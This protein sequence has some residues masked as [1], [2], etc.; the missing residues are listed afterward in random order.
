MTVTGVVLMGFDKRIAG[1]GVLRVPEL[2]LWVVAALGGALGIFLGM[3]IFRHKT[4]KAQFQF[5]LLGVFVAQLF[6]GKMV[7]QHLGIYS[8]RELLGGMPN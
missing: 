3:R 8:L 5:L 7:A 1:T 4:R 6:I 2:I